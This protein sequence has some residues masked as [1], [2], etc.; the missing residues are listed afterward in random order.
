MRLDAIP[1]SQSKRRRKSALIPLV[2]AGILFGGLF[3]AIRIGRS[4]AT[5][6]PRKKALIE[7]GWDAPT[8]DLV[9][10]NIKIMEKSPFSGAM[11]NLHVGK[12][13]LNKTA[14]P[15]SAFDKDRADLEAVSSD[16]FNQ[17]F[18]T[19]WS[20]REEGWDWM[21]DSDWK[22]AETNARNFAKTAKA[23][24]TIA[25]FV[26]D[27]EP[28]G[29]NPWTYNKTLYPSQSFVS[30]QTKVRERGA[31]FMKAVQNEKS[32]IKIL[33]LFGAPIVKDQMKAQ[34]S[35]ENADWALWASF[36]D[37]MVEASGPKVELIDGNET[38]YYYLK[39]ADFDAFAKTKA[40]ARDLFS[41]KNR[42]KYDKKVR[43]ANAV[44]VDG[45]LNV[46]NSPRFIG[47]Y[48]ANGEERRKFLEHNLF[49][50]LRATDQYTWFYNEHMDWWGSFGKGVSVP[51]GLEAVV[52]S[53][54]E[55][56]AKG[57]PL[58]FDSA[59]FGDA[60]QRFANKIEIDGR[61]S[62]K[63]VG[64]LETT[65]RTGFEFEG[66]DSACYV[67]KIDG[68]FQCFVPPGWSG[69]ITPQL[70]GYTFNPPFFEAQNITAPNYDV[71][72]EGSPT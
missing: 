39:G 30:V 25:G 50:A 67:N 32:N 12:T 9:R 1:N 69:K 5:T 70:Q 40:E 72:F 68:Y 35:L 58:G 19:M 34:K 31:A 36:M 14:Y 16:R 49:H 24:K 38:S 61:V 57:Q 20:A 62:S 33:M 27:P 43:L 15:E 21:N 59:V 51:D 7:L 2:L 60:A 52:R 41:P 46:Y 66:K 10:N 28:Y 65:L 11:I 64:L 26:L 4:Q 55:K 22:A 17:N 23:G 44:F 29:T 3:S 48:L 42:D 54:T 8:P 13:F 18:I 71:A 53:A 37:G 63:G 45:T 56:T 6:S 47:L